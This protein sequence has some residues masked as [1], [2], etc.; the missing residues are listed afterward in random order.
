MYIYLTERNTV[1]ELIPDEN[2]VFPGI[3]VHQRYAPDFVEKL[4]HVPDDAGVKENW[5][6]DPES[7]TFSPPPEPEPPEPGPEPEDPGPT[8]PERVEALE[9]ENAALTAAIERGLSL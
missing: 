4:L 3:P 6:Y 7:G 9:E 5:V 8:L 2:P 1:A